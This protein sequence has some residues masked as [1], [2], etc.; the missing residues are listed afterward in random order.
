MSRFSRLTAFTALVPLATTANA[1]GRVPPADSAVYARALELVRAGNGAAGR[2]LVDSM[3]TVAVPDTPGYAEALYWRARLAADGSDAERDY[4]RIVVDYPLSPRAGDAVLKLAQLEQARGDLPAARTHFE[5]FLL[6][7]PNH[8]DRAATGL[9][10]AR[11]SMDAGDLQRGCITLGRTLREVPESSVELRN[12]LSYLNSRCANVD[13]T[14]RVAAGTTDTA[15]ARPDST[16]RDTAAKTATKGR[17]T[18]QVASYTTRAE[19]DRL[20]QRLKSRNLEGRV[21]PSGKR[22][23]VHVGRY[24]T[25][26]AATAAAN[27]LK[28]QKMDAFVTEIDGR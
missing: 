5:R 19:A 14:R 17:Y 20:V 27:K 8:P 6:E 3:V 12:Q 23:R 2:V 9:T 26:A 22:F 18:V 13:T 10:L 15:R 21:V 11:L 25:R 4:R 24:E 16:K 7:N 1:Q 28:A